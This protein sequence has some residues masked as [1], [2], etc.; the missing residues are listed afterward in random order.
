[1]TTVLLIGSDRYFAMDCVAR[2]LD[3]VMVRNHSAARNGLIKFPPEVA[4]L[5]VADQSDIGQIVIALHQAG[6]WLGSFAGIYTNYEFS[7]IAAATLARA[8]GVPGLSVETSARMRDKGLQK[9]ALR[10]AGLP[11]A[12]NLRFQRL[13]GPD[14]VGSLEYP[15][16]VKPSAGAAARSTVRV[17]SPAELADKTARLWSEES[18]REG[19]V[20][21]EYVEGE[22]YILDGW[23]HEGTIGF[24]S[25][26][27]YAVPCMEVVAS[28]RPLRMYRSTD[29]RM[30]HAAN[31]LATRAFAAL[32]LRSSVFHLE[33]FVRPGGEL[34]FGECAARRGGALIEEEV[35]ISRG[36][37]LACAAVDLALGQR[38]EP[39]A[40][41]GAALTAE[42]G[43]TY[44]TLPAGVVLDL[45]R[46]EELMT[47]P[48]VIYVK[49]NTYLGATVAAGL[50][51]TELP[52][53]AALATA[54]S[55][56]NLDARLD[57]ILSRFAR[58]S[59]VSPAATSP[60]AMRR[61]QAEVLGRTDL[62][63]R[64]LEIPVLAAPAVVGPR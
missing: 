23:V 63:D 37:S 41:P 38:P 59:R 8:A 18:A 61:Y 31:D 57:Q 51:S 27:R 60:R 12:R 36:V 55:R 56:D 14:D 16:V 33:F 50:G 26:G 52:A 20:V 2:G 34:V 17:D 3:V 40:T 15:L 58:G 28:N 22:E 25:L 21:E 45:A 44:L 5:N 4:E 62:A 30:Q 46:R 43:T 53:G 49:Y 6:Y 24:S 1:M 13:P 39:K 42:I 10:V 29:C 64:P 9:D 35:R 32:G 19:V 48:G 7:V 11:T 54:N 47:V